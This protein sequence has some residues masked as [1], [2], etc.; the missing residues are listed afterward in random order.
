ML[1]IERNEQGQNN[2][3]RRNE[4]ELFGWNE[5]YQ[6]LMQIKRDYVDKYGK[7]D[8]FSVK[9]MCLAL[10]PK[11]DN[12]LKCVDIVTY[13]T[14]NLVKYS[15]IKD[16]DIDIYTNPHSI[17]REMRALTVNME[18]EDIVLCP[19]RKFFNLNEIPETRIETVV[20]RIGKANCVEIANKL[21]GSMIVARHYKGKTVFSGSKSLDPKK[22]PILR[23]AYR[24]LT[25]EIENMLHA[26]PHLTFIFEFI[27]LKYPIVVQYQKEQEGLYLLG[28]REM[29]SGRQLSFSQTQELGKAFCLDKMV[30][31]EKYTLDEIL[32]LRNAFRCDEKEGWVLFVD[33]ILYKAKC[34]DY[35]EMHRIV[36]KAGSVNTIIQAV[37]DDCF[38][39]LMGR[40]P[41]VYQKKAM[42]IA[43]IVIDYA[44]RERQ[45]VLDYYEKYKHL[46]TMKEFAM[47]IEA[48]PKE[49]RGFL[50]AERKG[51][52]WSPLKSRSGKYADLKTITGKTAFEYFK[53]N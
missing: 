32:A 48:V 30:E 46:E 49:Y 45:T 34:S 2:P 23:A 53:E 37:A 5:G 52:P 51:T 41:A 27:S 7:A 11:Y 33:G 36:S 18:T 21:D 13:G 35:L 31:I 24:Y 6:Y 25:P 19:F 40:L 47:A 16:G 44:Q 15:L 26:N 9:E 38:D 10:A 8:T 14:W 3:A 1:T 29:S 42:A 39:D 17:Y 20:D 43:K 22:A 50:I 28:A 12:F 4:L